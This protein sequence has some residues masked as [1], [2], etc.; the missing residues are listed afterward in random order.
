MS[1]R[2]EG[3]KARNKYSIDS[4]DGWHAG[5]DERQAAGK[6]EGEVRKANHPRPPVLLGRQGGTG[7]AVRLSLS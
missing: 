3:V 5:R 7:E 4:Y 6:K 2:S 1:P